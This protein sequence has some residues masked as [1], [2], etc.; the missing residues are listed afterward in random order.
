MAVFLL[1]GAKFSVLP[2]SPYPDDNCDFQRTQDLQVQALGGQIIFVAS[3]HLGTASVYSSGEGASTASVP[4]GLHITVDGVG[5]ATVMV[6]PS[7]VADIE[8]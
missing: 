8:R 1:Y 2:Q 6:N 4:F 7:A 3:A 5:S